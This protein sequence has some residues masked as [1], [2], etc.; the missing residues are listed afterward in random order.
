MRAPAETVLVDEKERR[1]IGDLL[2][3]YLKTQ[4]CPA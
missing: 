2:I 1:C 3:A 4:T